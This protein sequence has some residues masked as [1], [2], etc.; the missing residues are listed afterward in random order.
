[1][2]A[3]PALR[4]I[5]RTH[6]LAT[7]GLIALFM[8]AATQWLRDAADRVDEMLHGDQYVRQPFPLN[9]FTLEVSSVNS[10]AEA[11][12]LR[13]GDVVLSVNGVALDGLTGYVA[14]V[15]RARFGDRLR[16]RIR[17]ITSAGPIEQDLSLPLPQFTYVGYARGGSLAYWFVLALRIATPFLCMALGFWVAAVRVYDRAAWNLLFMM[18]SVANLVQDGRTIWG[19]EDSLQPFFTAFCTGLIR[20]GPIALAY[21]GI[22][23]PERLN[24]DRKH[25]WVKW[26]L[27][28]P[29]LVRAVFLGFL[30]GLSLHD[31]N[32]VLALRPALNLIGRPGAILELIAIAVFF[33]CLLYKTATALNRDAR[34]RLLLLDTAAVLGLLPFLVTLLISVSRGIGFQGWYAALSIAM[35]SI[36]P[37]T[38]AYV[39]VVGR[40]MDVRVVVRQG[41]QYLLATGSIRVLQVV[42]SVAI[43]VAAASMSANTSV[44]LRVAFI[45]L[46]F[47]LL[48]GVRGFAQRLRG[49]IDRRFFREAYEADAILADL[50]A[51][52]RTMTDTG[53][54]LETVATRIAAAL[55]VARVAI[56]LEGG[57]AFRPAYALGYPAV[58]TTSFSDQS[59]TVRRLAKTQHALV[60]FDNAESWV[61][62]ANEDERAALQELRPE[63]LLP[64]S[65]NEKVLGIISL[66]P[67][68]SE[69]PFSK[70]DIRLLDSVAAQTGLALEN[71][72]LTEA[73]K[74]E[75]AAREKRNRELELA[76]EVQERLFPQEF[77]HLPGFD[78]AAKCRPALVVGGD[79]YDF[80]PVSDTGLVIAIGD[81]SGKGISAALLMATLRAFLRGQTIDRHTDLTAVIA[82]LNRLVY[83]SSAH[84]RYAT[85]FL[86]VVDS[87]SRILNYVNAGHNSPI[88]LRSSGADADV[89]RL[90]E[91]GTVVGLMPDGSWI[92]GQ[93]I[94][95]SGDLLVAFTDGISEAMNA[96]D[97]EWGVDRLIAALRSTFATPP[98]V[99]LDSIM[100]SADAF[101]ASAPQHDDMTLIIMRTA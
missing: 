12:G 96:S 95:R 83:E 67:K 19:H 82:N 45:S 13:E 68:R 72:R 91:G 46:G 50:A 63:L 100:A 24:F 44:A 39:I 74:A 21:F 8:I 47:I 98:Q 40:A 73:V 88:L 101:V 1:M 2:A 55:H 59:L 32:L 5:L 78:Y 89:L 86:A 43:I 22:T 90:D 36:F 3:M 11:A 31:H 30:N 61:Q 29:L 58:P 66:G 54:L 33:L 38:M 57:G 80:I 92:Q 17:R 37:L 35:L 60:D 81:I 34:R 26:I 20:L 16:I 10:S 87:S 56:L 69:E 53:P 18:L 93:V 71:G 84:D 49:W 28:G 85:F 94:L 27:L 76:R 65:L 64:L 79:Y 99:I 15:R 42:I 70:T 9:P 7:L 4:S 48:G 97:E 51:K 75:A 14:A 6:P 77:P 25:P 62:L 52:V 41:V 23:F